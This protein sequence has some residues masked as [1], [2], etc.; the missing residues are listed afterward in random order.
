MALA[1]QPP[2]PISAPTSPSLADQQDRQWNWRIVDTQQHAVAHTHSTD[3]PAPTRRPDSLLAEGREHTIAIHCSGQ[4]P[5]PQVRK[6][7]LWEKLRHRH[8][9]PPPDGSAGPPR[10]CP[11]APRFVTNGR[12]AGQLIPK[13]PIYPNPM[14]STTFVL[15]KRT[16]S[17]V[18]E[19]QGLPTRSGVGAGAIPPGAP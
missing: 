5:K 18:P 4:G 11:T 8:G 17:R 3:Q 15:R 7:R 12:G 1:H 14:P 2:R 13:A 6:D 9:P 10:D 19:L 16:L